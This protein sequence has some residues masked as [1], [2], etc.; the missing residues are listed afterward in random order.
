MHSGWHLM[1]AFC[2]PL[3]IKIKEKHCHVCISIIEKHTASVC[4][5]CA[6]NK[7]LAATPVHIATPS[8]KQNCKNR[9]ETRACAAML[10]T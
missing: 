10:T 4:M 8:F 1:M 5:G 7:R 3:R 9:T 6:T 2:F